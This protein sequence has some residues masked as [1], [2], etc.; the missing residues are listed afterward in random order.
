MGV[1]F[2]AILTFNNLGKVKCLEEQRINRKERWL[3][4]PTSSKDKGQ[5]SQMLRYKVRRGLR[6][7][8]REVIILSWDLFP[9]SYGCIME[10][11]KKSVWNPQLSSY[12]HQWPQ[13]PGSSLSISADAAMDALS[14]SASMIS[15]YEKSKSV[16]TFCFSPTDMLL[17]ELSSLFHFVHCLPLPTIYLW[18]SVLSQS[19][20]STF[21]MQVL[22][23]T[24]L[25][26][27]LVPH[28]P[29]DLTSSRYMSSLQAFLFCPSFC[30]WLFW[31]PKTWVSC[32]SKQLITSKFN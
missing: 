10:N 22:P 23:L 11:G 25:L 9:E 12:S 7:Y 3:A 31:K 29:C 32:W 2:W 6:V 21:S 18:S 4:H 13:N 17:R 19:L 14:R 15:L 26:S 27:P 16:F 1:K 28:L 30:L 24:D 20:L 8:G 5:Q